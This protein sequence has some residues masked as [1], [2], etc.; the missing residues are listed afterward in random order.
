M[1]AVPQVPDI[2]A[3]VMRR[4]QAVI[5]CRVVSKRPEGA[6]TPPEFVR[7]VATGGAGRLH[8]ATAH[9]QLTIDSYAPTTGRAMKLALDVDGAMNT[10]PKTDAPVGA[11]TGT[12]P[13]EGVDDSTVAKRVTATYQIT[14]RLV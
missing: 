5:S 9:A 1:S 12:C 10:L 13:A 2:K 4:L 11:V 14:A 7:V 3:E 8:V 6:D